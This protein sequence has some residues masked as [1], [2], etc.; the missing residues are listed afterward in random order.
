MFTMLFVGSI[1]IFVS[2]AA[3]TGFKIESKGL[4]GMVKTNIIKVRDNEIVKIL[5]DVILFF[6]TKRT[7]L[8]SNS[9]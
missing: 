5:F 8:I 2:P 3:D 4:V 7:Y 9:T 6:C 1:D